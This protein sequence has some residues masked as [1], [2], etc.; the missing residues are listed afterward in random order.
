M[1][2][3]MVIALWLLLYGYRKHLS[4]RGDF[5]VDGH[6]GPNPNPNP[7]PNQGDFEG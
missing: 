1:S 5:E 2:I 7:Y 3:L 4:K 6:G